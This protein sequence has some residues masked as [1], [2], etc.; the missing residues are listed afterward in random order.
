MERKFASF[1]EKLKRRNNLVEEKSCKINSK[2]SISS[3]EL[4]KFEDIKKDFPALSQNIVYLDS[5]STT[6]KPKCVIDAVNDYYSKHCSNSGRGNYEWTRITN[7]KIKEVRNKV[8]Q[9]INADESEI[10]FTSGATESSNLIAYSYGLNCLKNGD[11][12]LFCSD[13]HKSTILP[14]INVMNILKKFGIEASSNEILIDKEGDYKED[15]LI[16][17]I[18]DKTKVVVLTH[19]HNV[20]GLEMDINVI[21]PRIK[22]KNSNCKIVLDCS[23]SV[24]HIK[25]DVKKLDIDF[26]YFSGHKMFADTGIGV[27]YIKNRTIEE[28]ELYKVGGGIDVENMQLEA[29]RKSNIMLE[30][31]TTN[32]S[33][34]I[35][36]G[37][38]IDY[39]NDIGIENIE[40]Y[41]LFLT[42][43]LYDELSKIPDIE[44]LKGIDKC[45][46]NL[47]FGIISFKI[48]GLDSS[49][50]GEVLSDY[51]IY[52]RTGDFCKTIPDDNSIRVSL[53]IYNTKEDIDKLIKV[54]KYILSEK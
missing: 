18:T 24:S 40:K 42:R 25:V 46:C 54:L 2:I 14:W 16:S 51:G 34:I 1:K 3:Q 35:S 23:Q 15:D 21:V 30:S 29:V 44:F 47:G 4:A 28:L 19:I 45:S 12:I 7:N 8:A 37:K 6:Q 10:V 48:N 9:F 52:V 49:E 53:H 27:C 5:S 50:V 43:Y 32:I 39:I 26:A 13:D 36:L 31:G 17:K 20:Y 38:A 11:E 41:M 22:E 33:G